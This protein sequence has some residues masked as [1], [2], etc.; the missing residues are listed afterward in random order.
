MVLP[1]SAQFEPLPIHPRVAHPPNFIQSLPFRIDRQEYTNWCWAATALSVHKFFDATTTLQQFEIVN[2]FLGR[3]DCGTTGPPAGCNEQADLNLVFV[4]RRL[5][6]SGFS[7][8]AS[9]AE[10]TASIL[11]NSPICVRIGWRG[12]GGHAVIAF[13]VSA[14]GMVVVGDPFEGTRVMNHG[15]LR[16]QYSNLGTWTHTIFTKAP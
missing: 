8:H 3:G 6:R 12:G 14:T 5:F 9:I 16:S 10:L 15:V 7:R 13:G 11:A 1:Q 2:G 4:S